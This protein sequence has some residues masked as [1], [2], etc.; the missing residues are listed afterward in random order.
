MEDRFNFPENI[1]RVTAGKGSC[2]SMLVFSKESMLN[3]KI[4]IFIFLFSFSLYL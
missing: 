2:E 3:P 1:V 4:E